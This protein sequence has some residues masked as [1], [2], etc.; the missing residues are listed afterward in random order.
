MNV[1]L[2]LNGYRDRKFCVY[3]KALLLVINKEKLFTII[4][5]LISI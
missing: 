5:V 4:C 1:C 3:K 2:I